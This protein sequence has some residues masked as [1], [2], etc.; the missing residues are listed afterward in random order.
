MLEDALDTAN[1]IEVNTYAIRLLGLIC[2]I[3]CAELMTIKFKAKR[4]S[5][6]KEG[7]IVKDGY[8][9]V[10]REYIRH[11]TT[12]CI[13]DQYKCDSTLKKVG[14]VD[15]DVSNPDLIRFNYDTYLQVISNDDCDFLDKV[16]KKV[17]VH[18]SSEVKEI[19]LNKKIESLKNAIVNDNVAITEALNK[20]IDDVII[21]EPS[22]LTPSTIKEFQQTVMKYSKS[23]VKVALRIIQIATAQKWINPLNAI[24]N[25]EKEVRLLKSSKTK[26]SN[27]KIATKDNISNKKKY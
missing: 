11:R 25:Y 8:M 22:K 26:A 2:A 1:S 19:N 27:L 3:Y 9:N 17:K 14:I 23:D 16:K 18:T 6:R 13:E 20:W 7:Y 10:D 21:S 4:K 12:I 24:E 5:K 15:Y